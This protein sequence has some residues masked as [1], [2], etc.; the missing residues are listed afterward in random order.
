MLELKLALEPVAILLGTLILEPLDLAAPD[1]TPPLPRRHQHHRLRRPTSS[2]AQAPVCLTARCTS[3]R[4]RFRATTRATSASAS[5]A[6]SSACSSRVLRRC[7]V[8]WS[9][10]SR[11]SAV[12]AMSAPSRRTPTSWR[13]RRRPPSERRFEHPSSRCRAAKSRASSTRSAKWSRPHQD[14]A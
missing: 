13:Y 6:T 4:S 5:A 8:A 3:R 14:H 10:P 1:R 9:S 7:P 2:W 11:A 12:R